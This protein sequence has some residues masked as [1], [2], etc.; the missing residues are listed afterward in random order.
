V[1]PLGGLTVG[2]AVEDDVVSRTLPEAFRLH[3]NYP[4]PFNP[5]TTI[6]FDLKKSETVSLGVFNV[7]GQKVATLLDS[8]VL[9][10][11]T[12]TVDFNAGALPSG[13]YLYVLE[14]DNRAVSK[15]MVL[16]K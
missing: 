6:A 11:G 13:L 16:L 9:A 7:L 10:A 4:N 5:S 8:Q 3:Q 12:Q 2:T 1:I 14:V 15:K